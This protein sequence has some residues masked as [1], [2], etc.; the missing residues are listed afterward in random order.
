MITRHIEHTRKGIQRIQ[1]IVNGVFDMA[2]YQKIAPL[3]LTTNCFE[4]KSS[5]KR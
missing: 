4:I 5:R 3:N 1:P 2:F